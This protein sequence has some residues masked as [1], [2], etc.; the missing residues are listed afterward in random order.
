MPPSSTQAACEEPLQHSQ[1]VDPCTCSSMRRAGFAL[2]F[3]TFRIFTL[4][5]SEFP[6]ASPFCVQTPENNTEI[7]KSEIQKYRKNVGP[8]LPFTSFS[9]K[10]NGKIMV[11]EDRVCYRFP[12]ILQEKRPI[13]QK[14]LPEKRLAATH[15]RPSVSR[16]TVFSLVQNS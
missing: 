10:I 7:Q 8:S 9:S 1:T 11:G 5:T 16:Q 4:V 6:K 15:S 14:H 13:P 12:E 3:S 2:V